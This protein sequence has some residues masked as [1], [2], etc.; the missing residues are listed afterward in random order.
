[1]MAGGFNSSLS[2]DDILEIESEK[3]VLKA[4][5][6]RA[7]AMAREK[8]KECGQTRKQERSDQWYQQMLNGA[9]MAQLMG[10]GEA[11]GSEV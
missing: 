1:M 6:L 10:W 4:E 5:A 3:Q 11:V 7:A 9:G 8:A 2:K